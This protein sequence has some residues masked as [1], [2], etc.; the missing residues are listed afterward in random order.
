MPCRARPCR[1]DTVWERSMHESIASS[2]LEWSNLATPIHFLPKHFLLCMEGYPYKNYFPHI[3][4]FLISVTATLWTPLNYSSTQGVHTL[5]TTACSVSWS[6]LNWNFCRVKDTGSEKTREK[7]ENSG[8]KKYILRAT[9]FIQFS[10][11]GNSESN[12]SWIIINSAQ[13]K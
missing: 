10:L 6:I 11:T 2:N 9:P 7:G 1:A 4:S 8:A 12:F 13:S 3:P 5:N